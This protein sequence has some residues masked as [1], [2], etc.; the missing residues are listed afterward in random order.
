MHEIRIGI[1][2][3][4]KQTNKTRTGQ[5]DM[6]TGRLVTLILLLKL[7]LSIH[8]KIAAIKI[9]QYLIRNV[10]NKSGCCPDFSL[11]DLG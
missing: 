9:S 8:Q 10:P 7:L 3:V 5:Q 11:V 6:T 4:I 2:S 1:M